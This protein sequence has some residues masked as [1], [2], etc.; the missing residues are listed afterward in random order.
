METEEDWM[1]PEEDALLVQALNKFEES[2]EKRTEYSTDN[3]IIHLDTPGKQARWKGTIKKEDGTSNSMESLESD[4][5]KSDGKP[6]KNIAEKKN[7]QGGTVKDENKIVIDK[8][9]NIDHTKVDQNNSGS[10]QNNA[11]EV[12]KRNDPGDLTTDSVDTDF[13]DIP[14][15]ETPLEI[16]RGSY[17]KVTDITAQAWCE[18]QLVYS[19]SVPREVLQTPAMERGTDMHLVKELEVHDIEEVSVV[20]REDSWAVKFLNI[21]SALTQLISGSP[22]IR[23]MPIFGEPFGM[24]VFFSGI[25]DEIRW[26]DKDQLELVEF[27]TR[28]KAKTLPSSAQRKTHKLQVSIYKHLFDTAV[29]GLFRK[30]SLQEHLRLKLDKTLSSSVLDHVKK[31]GLETNNLNELMDKVLVKFQFLQ[32][33]SCLTTEYTSQ[34]DFMS[35]ASESY[36]FDEEWLRRQ[37]D[38]SLQFWKGKRDPI[39]VDIEDAWKCQHCLFED[40]CMWRQK[41]HEDCIKKNSVKRAKMF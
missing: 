38:G 10:P 34:T 26:N 14:I 32:L 24:G 39:G 27:K 40:K 30:E 8:E 12:F 13:E 15:A 29:R 25:I 23:E 17:L 4:R 5:E 36:D 37:V 31:I 3:A 2:L 1:S 22:R 18:Q 21:Y 35:F 11:D 20:T 33:I 9:T 7:V 41:M 19:F 16:Y 6:E 28:V